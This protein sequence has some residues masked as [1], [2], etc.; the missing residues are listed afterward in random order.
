M[1]VAIWT[2][3]FVFLCLASVV[4]AQPVDEGERLKELVAH[5]K[6]ILYPGWARDAEGFVDGLP[7]LFGKPE[8]RALQNELCGSW[9]FA[10]D[11]LDE[12]ADDDVERVLLLGSCW[13]MDKDDFPEFLLLLEDRVENGTLSPRIF[14]WIWYPFDGPSK[15]YQQRDRKKKSVQEVLRRADIFLQPGWS[16]DKG[17]EGEN[18]AVVSLAPEFSNNFN[19]AKK[20]ADAEMTR[21]DR[22]RFPGLPPSPSGQKPSGKWTRRGW[23]VC[24][25]VLTVCVGLV[26][27]IRGARRFQRTQESKSW[28]K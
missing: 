7:H 18:A 5:A 23:K 20:E 9:R 27:L 12:L 4:V 26:G 1:K 3:V 8:F 25:L 21:N 22:G 28:P 15:G 19:L 17:M 11:R 16:P 24:G 10:V 6:G 2:K 13:Y 14:K